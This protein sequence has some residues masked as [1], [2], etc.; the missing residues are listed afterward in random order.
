MRTMPCRRPGPVRAAFGLVVSL[1]FAALA[2]PA[3]RAQVP[4]TWAANGLPFQDLG[5]GPALPATP[6]AVVR[7]R[8]P[9]FRFEPGFLREPV[10]LQD[11]DDHP[12]G[13]PTATPSLPA[14]PDIGPDWI[15]VA[16]GSDNPYFD[17]RQRGDP[18]GLGYYRLNTQVQLLETPRTSCTVNMQAVSPAGLQYNG[19]ADGP[20][21]VSPAFALFHALDDNTALQ[22]YVGKNLTVE[23]AALT[24]APVQRN[25]RYGMAVQRA[26]APGGPD[27]LRDVY[28][29]VGAVGNYHFDRDQSSPPSVKM[30]PGLHWRLS[31]TSWLSGGVMVPVG[32]ARPEGNLP[33]QFTWSLQF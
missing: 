20:T 8:I 33:W 14:E 15:Q 17:F 24:N 22:G 28:L 16:M 23:H 10:G 18:G 21:V 27:V 7:Q 25:M 30:L 29:Y 19:L 6:P 2:A 4:E 3:A 1:S 31:D 32:T 9:L 5:L 13:S 11:E 26:L 12:P